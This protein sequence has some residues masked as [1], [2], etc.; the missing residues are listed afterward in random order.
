MKIL[1]PAVPAFLLCFAGGMLLPGKDPTA[2]VSQHLVLPLGEAGGYEEWKKEMEDLA[3][4]AE[5][6]E[7]DRRAMAALDRQIEM[8]AAIK[9]E[10]AEKTKALEEVDRQYAVA[11]SERSGREAILERHRD[12]MGEALQSLEALEQEIAKS[13]D[14]TDLP[15]GFENRLQTVD[16]WVKAYRG[17]KKAYEEAKKAYDEAQAGNASLPPPAGQ[18]PGSEE[19]GKEGSP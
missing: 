15:P 3:K 1:L 9:G 11:R 12:K 13:A 18:A 7:D 4:T 2:P 6:Q 5:D 14:G 16:G 10:I 17:A 8:F 19:D